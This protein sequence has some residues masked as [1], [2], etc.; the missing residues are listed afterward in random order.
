MKILYD[1]QALM[2]Q[3]YGGVSIYHH[4]LMR[5][6]RKM[7]HQADIWCVGSQNFYFEKELKRGNAIAPLMKPQNWIR[8]N[9]I[10]TQMILLSGKYDIFHPTYHDDYCL[11]ALRNET[12]LVITVH[13]M[14]HELMPKFFPKD[15]SVAKE[16]K[17]LIEHADAIIA[18]SNNTKKDIIKFNPSIAPQKIHVIYQGTTGNIE[19]RKFSVP[20]RYV[21]FVGARSGYKNFQ[22]FFKALCPLLREDSS[23]FLL[24]TGG[25]DWNVSEKNLLRREHLEHKVLRVDLTNEEMN[26]AYANALCFVFPSEYEG[27]GRPI[28]EAFRNSCPCVLSN[29]SCFPEIGGDA[30]VY[31]DPEDEADIKEKVEL[32][33]GNSE[34]RNNLIRKGHEQKEKFSVERVARE[35]EQVYQGVLNI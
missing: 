1:Y 26:Y 18:I 6:L 7:G 23:L 35:T 14:I 16:K 24:C 8:L 21:L 13:D 3:R 31:F 29:A 28:L 20:E 30:A 33:I 12:K 5:Q 4:E 32:V 34:L 10:V 2:M 9:K 15:N 11:K 25:T 17:N 27:F 19:K 22:G